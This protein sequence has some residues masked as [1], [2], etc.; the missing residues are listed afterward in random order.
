L[1][2]PG[3]LAEKPRRR[4]GGHDSLLPIR[5]RAVKV[6]NHFVETTQMVASGVGTGGKCGL[7]GQNVGRR[8]YSR[9]EENGH[10]KCEKMR[11]AGE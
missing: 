3:R 5:A 7:E 9:Q 10:A 6:Q 8:S 11:N 1:F 4:V 2:S